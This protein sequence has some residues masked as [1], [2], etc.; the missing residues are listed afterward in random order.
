MILFI[1]GALFQYKEISQVCDCPSKKKDHANT[2][3]RYL[4]IIKLPYGVKIKTLKNI[5]EGCVSGF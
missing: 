1:Y 4:I 2:F 3:E 5:L